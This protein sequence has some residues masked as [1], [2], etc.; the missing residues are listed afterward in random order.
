M[1]NPESSKSQADPLS[2]EP[3]LFHLVVKG[4]VWVF[5][6]KVTQY[7][8]TTVRLIVLWRL[9]QVEDFGLIGIATLAIATI[10]TFTKTGFQDALIQKKEDI[11]SF[12]DSAWTVGLIRGTILFLFLYIIA[13]Y[14]AAIKTPP[15]RIGIATGIIQLVGFSFFLQGLSNI[16]I[17]YLQKEM[18]FRKQYIFQIFATLADVIVS[19]AIALMHRSAWALA[20]GLLAGNIVRC[21]F[22]YAIH[23]YRPR[24]KLNWSQARSLFRYGRWIFASTILVFLLSQGNDYFV[25]VYL[26]ITALGYYQIAYK[27]SNSPATEIT[28]VI[29]QVIFPAY[30]K[31]QDDIPRLRDA[32]LKV[33]QLIAFLSF[34][35]AGLIFIMA[36]DF[37]TLFFKEKGLPLIVLVQILAIKGLMR[38][39]GATIGPLFQAIGKPQLN[40]IL[41]VGLFILLASLIYPFSRTW[42]IAGTAWATAISGLIIQPFSIYLTIKNLHCRTWH[43]LKVLFY[44]LAGTIIMLAIIG[45]MKHGIFT[46][47]TYIS[48]FLL[49]LL[50]TLIYIIMILFCDRV[51]GYGMKKI[52]QEQLATIYSRQ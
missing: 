4:G 44:P 41:Q 24:F 45:V 28:N 36:P 40:T 13:P 17:I 23:P 51:F 7:L 38:S 50:G 27:I 12:L 42:G 8:L 9:L 3:K 37:I 52:L 26:G 22:S 25:W 43:M 1:N 19:V 2:P 32:Y 47:P 5:L 46:Q 11:R 21:G 39:F 29:S 35:L 18:D 48:F 20:W 33:L 15:D 14:A 34:P 31:M 6:L 49:S 16:G 10:E 30:A